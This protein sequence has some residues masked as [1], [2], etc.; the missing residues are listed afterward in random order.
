[1]G[2]IRIPDFGNSHETCG[3]VK[4]VKWDPNPPKQ[5]VK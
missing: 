5:M 3:G 2:V 4:Q 1:M